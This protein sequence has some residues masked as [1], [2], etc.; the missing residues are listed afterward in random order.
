MA[1]ARS[2]VT[3][4]EDNVIHVNFRKKEKAKERRERLSADHPSMQGKKDK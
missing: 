1:S 2:K 3:K 4:V